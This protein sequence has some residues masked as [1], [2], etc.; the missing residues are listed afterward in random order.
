[1]KRILSYQY[2]LAL[3]LSLLISKES[4]SQVYTFSKSTAPYND[5]VSP[6]N[7]NGTTFWDEENW[8]IPIGFKFLGH[9]TL[10]VSSNGLVSLANYDKLV[11]QQVTYTISAFADA[12]IG[13]DLIDRDIN[14]PQ[15][16]PIN[17]QLSGASP[18]QI[19]KIEW[20]NVGFYNSDAADFISFQLWLYEDS[21]IEMRYGPHYFSDTQIFSIN[22]SSGAVIGIGSYKYDLN[23]PGAKNNQYVNLAP[24]IYLTGNVKSPGTS[25]GFNSLAASDTSSCAPANETRFTFKTNY[26]IASGI[27]NGQE[28]PVRLYP[29][30][31]SSIVHLEFENKASAEICL[32]DATGKALKK[33]TLSAG[34]SSTSLD[35]EGLSKG[36]YIMKIESGNAAVFKLL[37][38][39]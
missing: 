27:T 12:S 16:S 32:L 5:L 4:F 11:D 10:T 22:S 29:N 23:P 1:M 8:V 37:S 18:S 13:A 31:A 15:T 25:A 2:A 33:T 35:I 6:I 38:I 20:K 36:L 24:S 26:S 14:N 17:Y 7:L 3:I 21:T 28:L 34:Q 30:P 39:Q 19:L 9:D